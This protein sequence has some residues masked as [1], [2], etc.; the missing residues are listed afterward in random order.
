MLADPRALC[1]RFVL[2][3]FN[4]APTQR[5]GGCTTTTGGLGETDEIQTAWLQTQDLGS[6]PDLIAHILRVIVQV[7]Q[8]KHTIAAFK[9]MEGE[10]QSAPVAYPGLGQQPVVKGLCAVTTIKMEGWKRRNVIIA[11]STNEDGDVL[12]LS[13]CTRNPRTRNRAV[14]WLRSLP[15]NSPPHYNCRTKRSYQGGL[16]HGTLCAAH[17]CDTDVWLVVQD[18]WNFPPRP[19][20]A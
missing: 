16:R 6:Y 12:A 4:T 19:R 18:R 7:L 5:K 8:V 20:A 17:G 10:S 13:L 9:I 15:P 3:L 14:T 1:Q 11:H 2:P